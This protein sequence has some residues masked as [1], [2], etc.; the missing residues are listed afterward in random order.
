ML[1]PDKIAEPA[2]VVATG[3]GAGGHPLLLPPKEI[4]M[5]KFDNLAL[6][7]DKPARMQII[8]PFTGQPLRTA[9]GTEAY[10]DVYSGDSVIARKHIRKIQQRAINSRGRARMNPEQAEADSVELLAEL[11]AGWF[12]V[13]FDGVVIDVP[14]NSENAR[15]LYA[16]RSMAWIRDQ[17]DAFSG[18]R[19]NF[20]RASSTS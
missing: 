6:E 9:D 4:K 10:V 8:H 7:V 18:E 17:V 19:A 14:F 15:E 16:E 3:E 1:A 11:S 13:G 5:S 12:L 2:G 20:S